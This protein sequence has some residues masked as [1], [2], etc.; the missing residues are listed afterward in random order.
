MKIVDLVNQYLINSKRISSE[1]LPQ[2]AKTAVAQIEREHFPPEL[3]T[4][5]QQI[6]GSLIYLSR[7]TRPDIAQAVGLLSRYSHCPQP[8]HEELIQHLLGYLNGTRSDQFILDGSAPMKLS[9]WT[10]ADW[11]GD[12]KDARSTTGGII[13]IGKCPISWISCKQTVVAPSTTHSEHYAM[14][15]VAADLEWVKILV[16]ELTRRVLEPIP[17]HCDNTGAINNFIGELNNPRLRAFNIRHKFVKELQSGNAIN[18]SYVDTASQKADLFTKITVPTTFQ[19][20][21]SEIGIPMTKTETKSD[22]KGG[23]VTSDLS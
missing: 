12:T 5:Y 8:I 18:V 14:A 22:G 21:R 19:S 17:V 23:A 6:I 13:F 11:A 16:E 10:D 7:T 20:L 15:T 2:S 4:R 1:P 9:C 3:I